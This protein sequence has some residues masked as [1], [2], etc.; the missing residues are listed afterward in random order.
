L[1]SVINCIGNE[2]TKLKNKAATLRASDP[3]TSLKRGFSLVYAENGDLVKSISQIN[4]ADTLKTKLVT[5]ISS[6]PSIRPKGNKMPDKK[7]DLSELSYEQKV[8]KLDEILTRLDN[9][10]TPIDKLAEDVKLGLD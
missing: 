10:E 4:A 5:D 8:E 3:M 2:K 1:E 9:S 7:D 6:A